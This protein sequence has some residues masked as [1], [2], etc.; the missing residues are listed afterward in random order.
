SGFYAN[1][2]GQYASEEVIRDYVKSQG[3]KYTKVY[4]GQ[5]K[6]DL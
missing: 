3:K 5:L 4:S 6:F 2:V 1:T